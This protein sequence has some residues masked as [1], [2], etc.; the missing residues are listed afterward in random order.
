MKLKPISYGSRTALAAACLGFLVAPASVQA[1][2]TAPEPPS[3]VE[4]R[5]PGLSLAGAGEFSVLFWDVYTAAL[6]V[7]NGRY[8]PDEPHVLVLRYARDFDGGDIAERSIR[9][10]RNLE[11]GNNEQHETWLE[12]MRVLFPDVAEGDQLSGLHLPGEKAVF[13]RNNQYIGE[14]ADAGFA[15]AFFAIWLDEKTAAPDLRRQLLGMNA[16][17]VPAGRYSSESSGRS[18]VATG[19]I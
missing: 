19:S 15:R 11:L 7:P 10:I 17:K 18:A 2:G 8:S 13:Y 9:E 6:W 16:G 14:I 5:L 1:A 4:E 3:G 12:K